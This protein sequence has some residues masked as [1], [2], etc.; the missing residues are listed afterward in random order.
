[1]VLNGH[2]SNAPSVIFLPVGTTD[3]QRAIVFCHE[4][5]KANPELPK[6]VIRGGGFSYGGLTASNGGCV[7]DLKRMRSVYVENE[8]MTCWVEGGATAK[9][10]DMAVDA[11]GFCAVTGPFSHLGVGGFA[12]GGG[13]GL[14]TY[15]YGLLMDSLLE[16][17]V[18]LSS[19]QI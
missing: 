6:T 13:Y 18:V 1:M 11:H 7:I 17:E 15:K 5:E 3:V 4:F 9:D 19:G 14:L 16:A 10:V 12:C 2:P 8:S